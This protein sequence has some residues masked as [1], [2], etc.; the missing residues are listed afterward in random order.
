MIISEDA[1]TFITGK[2]DKLMESTKQTSI[3]FVLGVD[4]C[5]PKKVD[6]VK[7][8]L[9]D[10]REQLYSIGKILNRLEQIAYNVSA[11]EDMAANNKEADNDQT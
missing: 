8:R 1:K 11:I 2:L 6:D 10:L 5:T 9:E 7:E 3:A 4:Y